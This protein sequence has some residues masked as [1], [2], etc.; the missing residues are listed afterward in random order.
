[1]SSIVPDGIVVFF[2][3]Y[4]FMENIIMKWDEMGILQKIL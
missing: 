1:M 2:P 4:M 3:S